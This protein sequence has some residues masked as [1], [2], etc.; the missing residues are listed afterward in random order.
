MGKGLLFGRLTVLG[1]G[2]RARHWL[3]RC[4]CGT[5][6]EFSIGNVTS[7]G[8]KSCGCLRRESTIRR[9]TKHGK[10][11]TSEYE[12]WCTII[13]RCSKKKSHRHYKYYAGRGIKVC[14]SWRKSFENFLEDMG[15]KPT[16]RHTI[17]RIDNDGDYEPGNCRWITQKEQNRNRRDNVLITY[18]GRTQCISAWSVELGIPAPTLYSRASK[19]GAVDSILHKNKV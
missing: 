17:D 1:L 2:T 6:K 15:L 4:S 13:S 12:T 9:F 19:H 8:T 3:C 5:E 18:N 14:S 16:P 11:R 10:R 7:G